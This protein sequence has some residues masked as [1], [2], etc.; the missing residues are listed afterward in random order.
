MQCSSACSSGAPTDCSPKNDRSLFQQAL[1][2]AGGGGG[3]GCHPALAGV[4]VHGLGAAQLPDVHRAGHQLVAVL[5]RHALPVA[6]HLG[7]LWHW[8]LHQR[9]AA[10]R[11]ALAAGDSERRTDCH[12]RGRGDGRRRAAPA[13]HLLCGA[14]LRHD[15]ADPPRRHLCRKAGLRHRG[16]RAHGGAQQRDGVPH[17]AADCGGCHCHGHRHP[18]QPLWPGALGHWCRRAARPD[19]GR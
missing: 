15:G 7:L 2:G 19:A 17:G 5:R 10:G 1:A 12:R 6:G 3:G 4:R 8:R 9:D 11:A 13:R 14:H 16:P 18:A